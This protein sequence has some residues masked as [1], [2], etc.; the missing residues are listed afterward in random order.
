MKKL[1][2][3]R[4]NLHLVNLLFV[5]LFL[6][7]ESSFSKC[8]RDTI[9]TSNNHSIFYIN[10]YIDQPYQVRIS[11]DPIFA[12]D[13]SMIF[14]SYKVNLLFLNELTHLVDIVDRSFDNIISVVTKIP[15]VDKINYS[16]SSKSSNTIVNINYVFTNDLV[17]SKEFQ[18]NIT[19]SQKYF[20]ANRTVFFDLSVIFFCWKHFNLNSNL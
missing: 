3:S 10:G 17:Q 18:N 6:H 20:I 4:L 8:K 14:D 2:H 12:R 5:F 1:L 19:S 11:S 16:N 13:F 9:I 7:F 15:I